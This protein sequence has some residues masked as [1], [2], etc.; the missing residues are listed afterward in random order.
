MNAVDRG[1]QNLRMSVRYPN[2][3]EPGDR[4][5]VTAPSAGVP[6]ALRPRLDFCLQHLQK[7]GYEVVTGD[8]LD[9]AGIDG[10][11][12]VD[13]PA[14]D[15]ADELQAMLCD[16]SIRVVIPPWGGELAVEVLP[17]LDWV[18]LR[19]VDPTW[20]VG[21]SDISTL[22][23]PLTTLGGIASVHGQNLMD[24]PYRVPK[25]LL[26]WLDV[27]TQ[28]AGATI[29]QG[30]STHHR[31]GGFDRWE[32]D[33]TPTEYA[34]DTSGSWHLLDPSAG[35]V[36]VSG[37]LI[38]GC[39]ETVSVLA[40]TRFGD[41]EA[42]AGEHAPEGL[43]LYVEASENPAFDVARHLWRMRL[44][45]WF[46]HANAVLVGRTRAPDSDRFTQVDAVRSAL[47]GIDV[48]VLLDVDFGHVPP[49]LV[50]VN[51]ALA[52]V[53]LAADVASIVQLLG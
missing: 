5:A 46:T 19:S 50:F 29:I 35:D 32:D 21:Y 7:L 8:Y 47:D 34:L 28:S 37:R 17:W 9:N 36:D 27:V 44:S 10:Q 14:S 18:A 40:G 41:V 1:G 11:G 13:A 12:I 38:G 49:H 48:P 51:G 3:L 39:I 23:L 20:V 24:T 4:I 53:R 2:P 16:P 43:I 25:P 26:S 30:A 31:A 22:L 15:R 52:R 45:G 33:P 6:A 42:F